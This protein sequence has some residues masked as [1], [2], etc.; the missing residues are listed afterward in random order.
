MITASKSSRETCGD[1]LDEVLST[2]GNSVEVSSREHYL[3]FF[4]LVAQKDEDL[5]YHR[6]Q[7]AEVVV[8]VIV[9]V[10]ALA[11]LVTLAFRSDL[12]FASQLA[13]K[14]VVMSS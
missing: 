6:R 2:V 3:L 4:R 5:D 7:L 10:P 8:M 9:V 13:S 14:F 1:I 11:C 12:R